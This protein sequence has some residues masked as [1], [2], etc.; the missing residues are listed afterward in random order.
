L[1]GVHLRHPQVFA[2]AADRPTV[3]AHPVKDL[4]AFIL[5]LLDAAVI[6]Q[7]V[8]AQDLGLRHN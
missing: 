1:L 6:A 4:A 3:G 5:Q 8:P 7:I 2:V